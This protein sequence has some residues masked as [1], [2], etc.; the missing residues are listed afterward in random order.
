M[1]RRPTAAAA[2]VALVPIVLLASSCASSP[3]PTPRTSGAGAEAYLSAAD[4][5]RA[6]E[7]LREARRKDPGDKKL[8][9]R[10][11]RTVEGIKHAADRDAESGNFALA[12]AG[13]QVLRENAS[14]FTG[15]A[16]RLSFSERDIDAAIRTCRISLT[17]ADCRRLV[18]AGDCPS[19]LAA[20]HAMLADYAG[21]AGVLK[22][23]AS[24]ATAIRASGNQE[25][26]KKNYAQAGAIHSLLLR[27]YGTFESARPPVKFSRKDLEEAIAVCR[28]SLTNEGLSEYRKGNLA[29][30]ISIWESLLAFD[31]GNAAV[32]KAVDTARSQIKGTAD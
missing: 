13:Y 24:A 1:R 16:A 28:V 21:D 17:C 11:A 12:L 25:L 26:E 32:R 29:K 18:S 3:K 19:A 10:Y 8:L 15:F 31:P 20:W 27:N 2:L 9:V 22:E 23:Y 4:F 30:A 14:D 5:E 6:I 7:P